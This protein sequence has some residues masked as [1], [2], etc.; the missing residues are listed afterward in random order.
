MRSTLRA[1]ALSGVMLSLNAFAI[2][3]IENPQP[4]A[5]ETGITAIT[6]WN[7][8]A[9]QITLRIDGG[10][11]IVAPYGSLRGDTSKAC[12]G[13]IDTGFAYLLNY[14]TL[15]PGP[16]TLQAFADGDLFAS[17]TFNSINLGAEFLI[18]KT[19]EYYLNNF[20]EYGKRA[21]VTWKQSTQNFSITGIDTAIAP[22][23][24]TY[25]GG[26][27]VTNSG[28]TTATNNGGFFEVD[29]HTVSFGAQSE[30]SIV[31]ANTGGSCTYRGTA[32]YTPN[33]GDIQVPAGTFTCTNGLQ[34]T[35]TSNRLVF[36]PIGFLGDVVLKFT[37]GETCTGAAHF[38]GAR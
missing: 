8:Q 36:D 29:A 19:G 31:S 7:C 23:D 25:Y 38:A 14:N 5:I 22:I 18:D 2:G 16:H 4:D 9:S 6:G 20:P 28:C 35:W 15:P 12:G 30:L 37:V 33:G 3:T 1:F 21:R 17:T 11:P 34:G 13:R 10:P 26:I 32:F 24:G 27:V